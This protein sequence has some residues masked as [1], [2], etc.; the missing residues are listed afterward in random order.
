MKKIS[1]THLRYAMFAL[2]LIVALALSGWS[3][4]TMAISL[5]IPKILAIVVSIAY[6]G[7]AIY[8]GTLANEYAKAD[9]S[10]ATTRLWTYALVGLSVGFNAYH[11][12]LVAGLVGSA[13]FAAP[14]VASGALFS[15]GVKFENRAALEASQRLPER[16]PRLPKIAWL[17]YPKKTFDHVSA[18]ILKKY[19]TE[20]PSLTHDEKTTIVANANEESINTIVARHFDS[21][22]HTTEEL[23]P[24]VRKDKGDEI[25]RQQVSK[26]LSYVKKKKEKEN[27]A[28]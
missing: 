18:L 26:S 21:G 27:E 10:S 8:M 22:I 12:F 17:R 3:L 23:V 25:T 14:S 16:L 2:T 15:E 11:G 6:D 28:P 4:F 5:G 1:T 24:L 20:N 13:F 9:Q 19:L 7:A